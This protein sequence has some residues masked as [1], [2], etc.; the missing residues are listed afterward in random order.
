MTLRNEIFEGLG[1]AKAA[2]DLVWDPQRDY[3]EEMYKA[4]RREN[5]DYEERRKAREQ[6]IAAG[7]PAPTQAGGVQGMPVPVAASTET[8]GMSVQ[9]MAMQPTAMRTGAMF[10]S[11]RMPRRPNSMVF[12]YAG[13]GMVDRNDIGQTQG[14]ER[15]ADYDNDADQIVRQ[16]MNNAVPSAEGSPA[17]DFGEDRASAKINREV[18]EPWTVPGPG[19]EYHRQGT[20]DRLNAESDTEGRQAMD[21]ARMQEGAPTTQPRSRAGRIAGAVQDFVSPPGSL[22]EYQGGQK[23]RAAVRQATPGVTEELSNPELGQRTAS[24]EDLYRQEAAMRTEPVPEVGALDTGTPSAGASRAAPAADRPLPMVPPRSARE[25][26]PARDPTDPGEAGGPVRQPPYGPAARQ[27]ND[28][29]E[30]GGT[31]VPLVPRRANQTPGGAPVPPVATPQVQGSTNGPATTGN[32]TPGGAAANSPAPPAGAAGANRP[33]SVRKALDD[34]TRTQ[35]YDP[36]ADAND[37]RNVRTVDAGGRSYSNDEIAQVL[38]G[39]ASVA[40][41][42]PN[43]EAPP[44]GTG[45]IARPT[46]QAYVQS[47][48]QGG[49][50]SPGEAMLAGMMSDYKMLLKQGRVQQAN[51]MAYGLIQA[52]SIEAAAYGRVAGDQIKQGDYP[53]ALKNVVAGANYLPDGLTFDVGPD[54]RSIVAT[55]PRTGQ[56]TG[57]SA[58]TPHH[59]LAMVSGLSDGT[60]LWQTLQSAASTLTKPDR[61]AEGRGLSNQIKRN[62]ISLQEQRLK[63]GQGGGGAAQSPAAAEFAKIAARL[64]GGGGDQSK[65][66]RTTVINQGSDDGMPPDNE[67]PDE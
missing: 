63:K 49:K 22:G 4:V 42:G 8:P 52:A 37:P 19:F 16:L 44:V 23:R 12:G 47:H 3:A 1:A 15:E 43:G 27:P 57:R 13:G 53:G 54:G 50:F 35:A 59:L 58:I 60:L 10:P 2:R 39:A 18:G 14:D 24:M 7:M 55:D 26:V 56:V 31:P 9:P 38:G 61:N 51:M 62:Q 64:S 25:P 20:T 67:Y 33:T 5:D 28:P 41:G 17:P 34:Q 45:T 6:T 32:N 65:V 48:S 36:V 46:F 30:T 29:G 40:K 11:P 21:T 66:S